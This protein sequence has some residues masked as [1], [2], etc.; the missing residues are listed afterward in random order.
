MNCTAQTENYHIIF[1]KH[2]YFLF[3]SEF[4]V[5][6]KAKERKLYVETRGRK[7]K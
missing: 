4:K 1:Y 6:H 2:S 5:L 3:Y 7:Q